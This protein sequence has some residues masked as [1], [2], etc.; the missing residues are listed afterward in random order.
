MLEQVRRE[1]HGKGTS[2]K[3]VRQASWSADSS[4]V[5]PN[6]MLKARGALKGDGSKCPGLHNE[7]RRVR[8]TQECSHWLQPWE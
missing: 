8:Q 7:V 4:R 2:I 1:G 6:L 5:R 3:A